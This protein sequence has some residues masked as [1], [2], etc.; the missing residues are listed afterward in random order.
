MYSMWFAAMKSTLRRRRPPRRC[1]AVKLPSYSGKNLFR[2]VIRHQLN[3]WIDHHH[4]Y[5]R[6]LVANILI[7]IETIV[8]LVTDY[9]REHY[10]SL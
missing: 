3:Q 5:F 4:H 6:E 10:F 7:G 8:H 2:M 1:C 9:L